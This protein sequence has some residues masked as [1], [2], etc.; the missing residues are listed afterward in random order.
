MV[1]FCFNRPGLYAHFR[2][3]LLLK[4][5]AVLPDSFSASPGQKRELPTPGA[6]PAPLSQLCFPSPP[7][8]HSGSSAVGISLERAA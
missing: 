7:S 2:L 5:V 6:F 4:S 8:C 1:S 3:L